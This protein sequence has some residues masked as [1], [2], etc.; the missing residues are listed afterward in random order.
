MKK[1]ITMF[2]AVV[3]FASCNKMA[4]EA[5]IANAAKGNNITKIVTADTLFCGVSQTK[6]ID[7]NVIP[8]NTTQNMEFIYQS[9]NPEVVSIDVNGNITGA[10]MGE[11]LIKV[12]LNN[13]PAI[14][15][16]SVVKVMDDIVIFISPSFEGLVLEYDTNNDG[17]IQKSEAAAV[18]EL[19]I[20]D[21][22]IK[23]LEVIEHFVNIELLDCYMNN[24]AFLDLSHNKAL[25]AL[26]CSSCNL[27]F[28]N[29]DSLVNLEYLD[30]SSNDL[31]S[32]N[33]TNCPKLIELDCSGNEGSVTHITPGGIHYG[34]TELDVSKNP[35]LEKLNA[36]ELRLSKIDVTKNPKLKLLRLGRTVYVSDGLYPPIEEIDLS[37]NPELED[38]EC[39]GGHGPGYGLKSLDLSKNP[40]LKGVW[41]NGND[42][43]VKL[44]L[45][46]N[47]E[48]TRL[49]CGDC[50]LEELVINK[51][52]KLEEMGCSSNKIKSLDLELLTELH[53]LRCNKNEIEE[54]DISNSKMQWLFAA[55]NK[56]SKINMG[57]KTFD[58]PECKGEGVYKPSLN[59]ELDNNLISE[60]DL[61]KQKYLC[62]LKISNN[63]LKELDLRACEW[64]CNLDCSNN[65][66][67]SILFKEPLRLMMSLIIDNNKLT[68][69]IDLSQIEYAMHIK[70]E[71]NQLD[72]IKVWKGFNPNETYR[73]HSNELY[74][75]YT[76]DPETKWIY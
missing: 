25:K 44:D 37:N 13:N 11:A 32:L 5:E 55:N 3:L 39:E 57:N 1:T 24:V 50:S 76:K 59:M 58:T 15:T 6:K 7:I 63:K 61:S 41:V 54:L 60:I 20:P 40:K 16:Q 33:V 72:A 28:L 66:L 14:S 74:N 75:S 73:I 48:L 71:N 51:C 17:Y 4:N 42:N 70:A 8:E 30:C 49:C 29:I 18:K 35:E 46:N 21:S 2:V 27:R 31:Q 38:F 56:I 65:M 12:T 45:S 67:T 36:Y 47:V 10:S 22:K 26:R 52:T 43:L 23:S 62:A 69:T 34:I 64:V 9:S 19:R 68:G 53:H